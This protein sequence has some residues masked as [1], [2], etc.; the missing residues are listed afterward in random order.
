MHPCQF[1]LQ[2]W[3]W[4]L[5]TTWP[6]SPRESTVFR[7]N[8]PPT[9]TTTTTNPHQSTSLKTAAKH[10]SILS[11]QENSTS[12]SGQLLSGWVKRISRAVLFLF[13]PKHTASH[14]TAVYH[15]QASRSFD[16]GYLFYFFTPPPLLFSDY[17]VSN[18]A[19]ATCHCLFLTCPRSGVFWGMSALFPVPVPEASPC[20]LC[21]G[22]KRKWSVCSSS[23]IQAVW[24]YQPWL[25]CGG[26]SL[27]YILRVSLDPMLCHHEHS[28]GVQRLCAD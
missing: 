3:L 23:S 20:G 24:L 11:Q 15:G 9:T 17:C 14:N 22:E 8:P 5:L 27:A 10:I 6:H 13:L 1:T 25:I 18:T 2:P 28:P 4:P 19:P 12:R 7:E 21:A 16:K 26:L